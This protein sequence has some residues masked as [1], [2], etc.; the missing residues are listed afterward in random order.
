[1][2]SR[3]FAVCT[4]HITSK[5]QFLALPGKDTSLV[6]QRILLCPGEPNLALVRRQGW[7]ASAG[8]SQPS[9]RLPKSSPATA[10]SGSPAGLLTVELSARPATAKSS[11]PGHDTLGDGRAAAALCRK[12]GEKRTCE[13][14]EVGLLGLD[15][16]AQEPRG[17]EV[18]TQR[19]AAVGAHVPAARGGAVAEVHVR[20]LAAAA[21]ESEISTHKVISFRDERAGSGQ[22][23]W[24]AGRASERHAPGGS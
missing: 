7:A 23:G 16:P 9:A 10:K 4:Q 11:F 6:T 21:T 15:D 5:G 17:V 19:A 18:R 3:R 24:D 13:G 20:H 8:V 2:L 12:R 22:E 14:D 1:M